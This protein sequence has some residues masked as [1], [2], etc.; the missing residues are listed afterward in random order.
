M[1]EVGQDINVKDDE[2]EGGGDIRQQ[3]E[4]RSEKRS[5]LTTVAAVATLTLAVIRVVRDAG[6]LYR[7]LKKDP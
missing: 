6:D 3:S 1:E 4:E 7:K 5:L 2:E